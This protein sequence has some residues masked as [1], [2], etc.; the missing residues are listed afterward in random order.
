MKKNVFLTGTWYQN[1]FKI[2]IVIR[3]I[4]SDYW[5]TGM[6]RFFQN[7]ILY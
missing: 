2:I 1:N 7:T 4:M 5:Y 3:Y 6:S